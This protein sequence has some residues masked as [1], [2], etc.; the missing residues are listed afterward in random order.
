MSRIGKKPIAVPAGVTVTVADSKVTVEGPKGKLE[1]PVASFITVAVEDGVIT[2][3][4][5]NDERQSR[6]FHGLT[7]AM[8]NNMVIG[9]TAG[10]EKRLELVGVG[11]V[12]AIQNNQLEMRVGM[13]NE[14]KI[15]IPAGLQV[16]C[17]DQTHVLITGIDKQQVTQ[18]A[19]STRALRPVEPY[20]GKGIRYQGENVRRKQGKVVAK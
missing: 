3:D 13:A 9:V 2:V 7:R 19:A 18:F 17:P 20:K 5:A 6:A 4:R 15:P 12:A 14:L 10:Y 16:T 8:I 11:Y 1:F